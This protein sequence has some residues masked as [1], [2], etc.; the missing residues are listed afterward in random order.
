M[1]RKLITKYIY[2]SISLILI[3][4]GSYA[5]DKERGRHV[6]L[7]LAV[8]H[9]TLSEK[10]KD[11][12]R[13]DVDSICHIL[14]HRFSALGVIDVALQPDLTNSTILLSVTW[15]YDDEKLR[16]YA[17]ALGKLEIMEAYA[18]EEF[19]PYLLAANDSLG[20]PKPTDYLTP[21][22]TKSEEF[23]FKN[24][25]F[26]VIAPYIS[27]KTGSNTD[28]IPGPVVGVTMGRDLENLNQLLQSKI[29]RSIWP[30]DA[31]LIMGTKKW[32]SS[33]SLY[34]VKIPKKQNPTITTKD[35]RLAK[36]VNDDKYSHK[37]VIVLEM[38]PAGTRKW[39]DITA[40]NIGKYVAIV[41]EN[42]V[43]CA[44]KVMDTI[45]KGGAM[46]QAD[47]TAEQAQDIANII[48]NGQM[49]LPL[50]IIHREVLDMDKR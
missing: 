50:H 24:P 34:A 40:R 29:L 16:T 36:A 37:E 11:I 4:S 46:I 15:P 43:F 10:T 45:T 39:K 1:S 47:L 27:A 49:P 31:Q 48:N 35:I 6:R 5:Q 22:R 7:T 25:V 17:T 20:A 21:Q 44:P 12:F 38:T 30:K 23:R 41:L 2:L 28:L 3:I 14:Q 26:A 9:P 8:E 13:K 32:D 33:Y 19:F 18:N 42:E